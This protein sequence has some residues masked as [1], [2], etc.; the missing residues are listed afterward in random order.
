MTSGANAKIALDRAFDDLMSNLFSRP[1][2]HDAVGRAAASY[3]S[4]Q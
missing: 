4:V 1:D 2:F 3:V